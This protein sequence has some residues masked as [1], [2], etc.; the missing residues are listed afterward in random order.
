MKSAVSLTLIVCLLES[1]LP[2]TAQ[3]QTE[4]A[5]PLAKAVP[6]EAVRLATAG[7]TTSSTAAAV[8]LGGKSAR[9]D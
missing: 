2:A 5:G 1:A 8:Q 4:T 9:S 7:E 6:R 3:E